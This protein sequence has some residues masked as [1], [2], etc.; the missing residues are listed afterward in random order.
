MMMEHLF[1]RKDPYSVVMNVTPAIAD[2]WICNCNTH[3]RKL[4]DA[5]VDRLAREM[6]AGRWRLTHQGIAFSTNRVL[7]DGQHRLWAVVLSGVTVPLRVFFNEQAEG[8]GAIDAVQARS[9]DQIITLAGG[10]GEVGRRELATL[11]AMITGLGAYMRMTAGEEAEIL[12]QHRAAMDFALEIL[13][14]ARFRG[15]ATAVTRAVLAR[16]YYSADHGQLRHFASVLQSGVATSQRDQPIAL[17]LKFLMDAAQGHRG[18]PE[19]RE[20]YGKSERA[21]QA[22]LAGES[23]GR[24]YAATAELFPLPAEVNTSAA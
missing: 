16:A 4:V 1:Q 3:N 6:K 10:H 22:F 11:R 23:L 13:P 5:H 24:L 17:L 8:L 15:V 9:N 14:A 2:T 19:A 21:L 18:R 7:L 12:A 20:K